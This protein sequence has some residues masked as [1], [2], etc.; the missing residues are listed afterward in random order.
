MRYLIIKDN[1]SSAN[2]NEELKYEAFKRKPE[3]VIIN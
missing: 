3:S 2:E 1:F